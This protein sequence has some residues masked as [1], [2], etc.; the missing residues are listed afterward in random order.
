MCAIFISLASFTPLFLA[1][2]GIRKYLIPRGRV[3]WITVSSILC[4]TVE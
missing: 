4:K 1:E 2:G 3:G